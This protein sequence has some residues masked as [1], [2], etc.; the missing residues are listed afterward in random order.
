M[1]RGWTEGAGPRLRVGVDGQTGRA[2][3]ECGRRAHR[4]VVLGAPRQWEEEASGTPRGEGIPGRGAEKGLR[5][6]AQDPQ[7]GAGVPAP[8]T[9]SKKTAPAGAQGGGEDAEEVEG[10]RGL[11]PVCPSEW[12]GVCT[13][14]F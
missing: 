1:R 11:C 8:Q 2:A 6:D 10:F 14:W 4:L 5:G 13:A 9:R 7:G 3:W 12:K